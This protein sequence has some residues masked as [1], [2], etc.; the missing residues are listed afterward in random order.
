MNDMKLRDSGN[1][2]LMPY[3]A[4]IFSSNHLAL[5]SATLSIPT[6]GAMFITYYDVATKQFVQSSVAA[7]P[8]VMNMPSSMYFTSDQEL[9]QEDLDAL[10]AD[11]NLIYQIALETA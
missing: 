7:S 5:G 8:I 9:T 11:P 10:N 3:D 2:S 1:H 6:T 4:P